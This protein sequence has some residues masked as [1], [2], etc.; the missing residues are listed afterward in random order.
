MN[1]ENLLVLLLYLPKKNHP[2]I[3]YRNAFI[4]H[5][6]NKMWINVILFLNKRKNLF[7]FS[8]H[9]FYTFANW[10]ISK[11]V[12][13]FLIFTSFL[14]AYF[15]RFYLPGFFSLNLIDFYVVYNVVPV[16]HINRNEVFKWAKK[17]GNE[18]FMK[19]EKEINKQTTATT[20]VI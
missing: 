5:K 8:I 3:N 2:K 7:L 4:N 16:I 15:F 10:I 1:I 13:I 19:W 11:N 18:F 12:C 17:K 14:F 9:H 6:S 20:I